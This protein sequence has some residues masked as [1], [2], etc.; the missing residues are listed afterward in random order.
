MIRKDSV[1]YT[2]KA[3]LNVAPAIPSLHSGCEY[4][5]VV[6]SVGF[7][8]S[9]RAPS[10][11]SSRLGCSV[12]YASPLRNHTSK[13]QMSDTPCSSR[14][15]LTHLWHA[16]PT[17]LFDVSSVSVLLDNLPWRKN[18]GRCHRFWKDQWTTFEPVRCPTDTRPGMCVR[19]ESL[20]AGI[21]FQLLVP[22]GMS[23]PWHDTPCRCFHRL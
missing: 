9:Q 15:S 10:G 12:E 18:G 21:A 4:S 17:T 11:I 5:G 7:V 20:A 3:R 8:L 2:E 23:D 16:C 14:L 1:V 19:V 13:S 6:E 22:G